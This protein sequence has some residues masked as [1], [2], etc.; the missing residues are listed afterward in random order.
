MILFNN[1]KNC[2]INSTLISFKL[3]KKTKS[4]SKSVNIEKLNIIKNYLTS[5]LDNLATNRPLF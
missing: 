4:S 5:L 3:L 2:N 1:P